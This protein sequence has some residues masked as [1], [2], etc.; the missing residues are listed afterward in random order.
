M[1]KL[2]GELIKGAAALS[3]T[4]VSAYFDKL[5]VPVIALVFALSLLLGYIATTIEVLV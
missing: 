3:L 5:L 1:I 4:A 2:N